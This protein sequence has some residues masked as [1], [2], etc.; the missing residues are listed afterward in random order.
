M[1]E[2]ELYPTECNRICSSTIGCFFHFLRSIRRY[3]LYMP[4]MILF[5]LWVVTS[6]K[7]VGYHF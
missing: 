3:F 4:R 1:W 2:N 7:K 6:I 5:Q